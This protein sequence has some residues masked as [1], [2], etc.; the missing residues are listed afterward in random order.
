MK[1]IRLFSRRKA[2]LLIVII[3]FS[4]LPATASAEIKGSAS[5][6]PPLSPSEIISGI[7]NYR[8]QYGLS[9]LQSNSLLMILAQGHSE[10]QASINNL[11]H[12]GPGGTSPKERAIAAGYNGG[13]VSYYSEI[14]YYGYNATTSMAI[15]WWKGSSIHN[16]MMLSSAFNEIGAGVASNGTWN[17]YTAELGYSS[18]VSAPP[19]TSDTNTGDSSPAESPSIIYAVPVITTTPR[20]DGAVI[21]IIKTGQVPWTLSKIYGIDLDLLLEQNGLTRYS[22]VFTGDEIIIIPSNTPQ[23]LTSTPTITATEEWTPTENIPSTEKAISTATT[24]PTKK[25]TP[26]PNISLTPNI[27]P[28]NNS[29]DNN[30]IRWIIIAAFFIFITLIIV[31]MFSPKQPGRSENTDQ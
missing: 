20:E 10:Y 15:N 4:F 2:L 8:S 26:I 16:S 24:I 6:F 17:Y 25:N 9:A 14:I 21:H 19:N 31:S 29:D 30:A 22:Y 23:P 28:D 27:E 7:N 11:T 13:N 1:I 5:A 12:I 3:G 18:G